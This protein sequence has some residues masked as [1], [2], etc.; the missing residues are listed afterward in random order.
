MNNFY[1]VITNAYNNRSLL[2]FNYSSSENYEDIQ[3]INL[4]FDP[5]GILNYYNN[6]YSGNRQYFD[7]FISLISSLSLIFPN[8][9]QNQIMVKMHVIN[10]RNFVIVL[11]YRGK[12][13]YDVLF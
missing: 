5:E 2:T 8:A 12:E 4:N 7:A 6:F 10:G 11:S 1:N 13:V 9:N 3:S